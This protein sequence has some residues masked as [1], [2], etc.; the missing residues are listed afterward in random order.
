[1]VNIANVSKRLMSN[2][3][4]PKLR[5]EAPKKLRFKGKGHEVISAV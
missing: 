1:M 2:L 3:G 5:Q 4:M